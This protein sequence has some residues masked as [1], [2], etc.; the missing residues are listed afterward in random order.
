[1]NHQD[2]LDF[3]FSNF[4]DGFDNHLHNSTRGVKLLFWGPV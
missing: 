1:M 4:I 3:S 2:K